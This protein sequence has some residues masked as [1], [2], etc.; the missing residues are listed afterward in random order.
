MDTPVTV[1][2][3]LYTANLKAIH[4][5]DAAFLP[6]MPA[7]LKRE[8]PEATFEALATKMTHSLIGGRAEKDGE[9]IKRTCK[10]LGIKHTYKALTAY[11]GGVKETE[12]TGSYVTTYC[13]FAH[14]VEDGEPLN[15]ECF[16]LPPAAV[17]AERNGDFPLALA[18][19]SAGKPF[20]HSNGVKAK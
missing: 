13:N 1:F 8:T 4:G 12:L 20:R 16:V 5:S 15:H 7:D 19:R 11:F 17:A 9:A 3:T 10:Q 14:R 2:I 18:L 6:R